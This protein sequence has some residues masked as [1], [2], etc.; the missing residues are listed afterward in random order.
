[1]LCRGVVCWE[2]VFSPQTSGDKV[3]VGDVLF[4]IETDKAVMA[5]ESTEDGFLAQILVSVSV[6]ACLP[7][8]LCYRPTLTLLAQM[9]NHTSGIPLN[10]VVAYMVEEQGEEVKIPQGKTPAK[11]SPVPAKAPEAAAKAPAAPAPAAQTSSATATKK[12]LSPAVRA[13]VMSNSLDPQAI[14]AT[15]PRGHLLKGCVVA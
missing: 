5:V 10:T 7:V 9:G 6:P 14:P 1:M 2:I 11:A 12:P 4:D 8:C 13:L 15:G 3:S